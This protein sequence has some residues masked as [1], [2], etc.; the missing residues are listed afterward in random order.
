MMAAARCSPAVVSEIGPYGR[1]VT[2]PA[3]ASLRTISVTLEGASPSSEASC[4]GVIRSVCH[5]VW[6]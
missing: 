2:S 6:L 4:D 3:A 1:W 5:S